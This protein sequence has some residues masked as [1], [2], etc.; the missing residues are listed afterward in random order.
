MS[1]SS[2]DKLED[3]LSREIDRLDQASIERELTLEE[4]DRLL[5]LVKTHGTFKSKDKLDEGYD[6]PSEELEEILTRGK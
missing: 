4:V 2:A 5:K 1:R 3:I 6:L